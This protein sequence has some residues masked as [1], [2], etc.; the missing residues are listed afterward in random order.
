MV[1]SSSL[2]SIKLVC[3]ISAKI[4]RKITH[5]GNRLDTSGKRG[6]MAQ[7]SQTYCPNASFQILDTRAT[8]E[9]NQP[10]F[11]FPPQPHKIIQA[12]LGLHHSRC[13]RLSKCREIFPY[14]LP[15]AC[16]SLWGSRRTWLDQRVAISGTRA[17]F[18][19]N[20]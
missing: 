3:T 12:S 20:R 6:G 4:S 13:G 14:Q 10:N 8:I 18:A 15:Q 5:A 11:P 17:R 19:D 2:F 16:Q 9:S 7:A 1:R